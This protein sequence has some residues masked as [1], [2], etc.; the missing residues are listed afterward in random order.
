M[1]WVRNADWV[2]G[3]KM[4]REYNISGNLNEA[5]NEWWG[6]WFMYLCNLNYLTY[7]NDQFIPIVYIRKM[8]TKKKCTYCKIEK[9]IVFLPNHP[10][11][12]L[13]K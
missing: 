12:N 5:M 2:I 4:N 13:K 10:S 11:R 7:Q 9:N 8:P 1:C 6:I 3:V